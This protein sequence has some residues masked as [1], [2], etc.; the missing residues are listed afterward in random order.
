MLLRGQYLIS[1]W[2]S[3]LWQQGYKHLVRMIGMSWYIWCN[4]P[5]AHAIFHWISVPTEL[6]SWNG[7]WMHHLLSIITCKD[8]QEG[9]YLCGIDSQSLDSQNRSST[10]K[11]PRGNK[12]W[13]L[14]TSCQLSSILGIPL[15]QKDKML[16]IFICIRKT[17]VPIFWRIMV[18]PRAEK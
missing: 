3:H 13:A 4:T 18:R 2:P 9:G 7:G 15:Q 10:W 6:A 1:E 5:Q 17:I 12:S 14:M 11:V 8:I 16:S